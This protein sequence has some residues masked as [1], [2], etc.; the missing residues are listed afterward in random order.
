MTPLP[1]EYVGVRPV[2]VKPAS[3]IGGPLLSAE[4]RVYPL[5]EV[6]ES[7]SILF[8]YEAADCQVEVVAAEVGHMPPKM[9][10]SVSEASACISVEKLNALERK[11]APG[12]S[13]DVTS[14]VVVSF[15]HVPLPDVLVFIG[16]NLHSAA[17]DGV[18]QEPAYTESS[19]A[20]D[21]EGMNAEELSLENGRLDVIVSIERLL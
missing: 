15:A 2:I 5:S 9:Y 6:G 12:I 18:E 20:E 7:L 13:V 8:E 16:E 14:L 1:L 17:L 19:P 10:M 11:L 21:I 3:A 4:S